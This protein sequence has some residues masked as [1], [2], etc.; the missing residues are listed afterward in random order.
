MHLSSSGWRGLLRESKRIDYI[1][2]L[3]QFICSEE[4]FS[5]KLLV[6]VNNTARSAICTVCPH[7]FLLFWLRKTSVIVEKYQ[8]NFRV[9]MCGFHQRSPH[10]PIYF[11]MKMNL[12]LDVR[13]RFHYWVN[14]DLK[15]V[16]VYFLWYFHYVSQMFQQ[17][18]VSFMLAYPYGNPRVMSSFDF[19]DSDQGPP[20]DGSGNIVS[21]SINSDGTCGNGW[22]CEHRWR[23]IFNMIGFRNA[24]AGTN[25]LTVD[26]EKGHVFPMTMKHINLHSRRLIL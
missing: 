17:M 9:F 24:V 18:A 10:F 11:A 21:P 3:F 1:C 25:I 7:T 16:F 15:L 26:I 19:S 8:L 20:Q 13:E 22:V 23:Q 14:V 4:K 6:F 2:V 12:H 5:V